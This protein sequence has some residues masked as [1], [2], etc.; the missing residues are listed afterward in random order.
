MLIATKH[1]I[2]NLNREK[3]KVTPGPYT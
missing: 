2:K 3:Y 1:I